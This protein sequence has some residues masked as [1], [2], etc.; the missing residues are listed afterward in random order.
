MSVKGVPRWSHQRV[1]TI[2]LDSDHALL[3][4]E[5]QLNRK[6]ASSCHSTGCGSG[7]STSHPPHTRGYRSASVPFAPA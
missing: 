4:Q 7:S 1:S 6:D 2:S 5:P 3:R